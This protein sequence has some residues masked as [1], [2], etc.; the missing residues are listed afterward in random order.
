MPSQVSS[1]EASVG[2]QKEWW[3]GVWAGEKIGVC[4]ELRNA[5]SEPLRGIRRAAG[6]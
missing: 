3:G 5:V 4:G 6:A 2:H 1:W